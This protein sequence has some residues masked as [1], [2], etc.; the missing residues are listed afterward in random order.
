VRTHKF[1]IR[2]CAPPLK[3]SSF[4]APSLVVASHLDEAAVVRIHRSL[5]TEEADAHVVLALQNWLELKSTRTSF[6][7][8]YVTRK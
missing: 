2:H 4:S 7:Y 5:G 3:V 6:G 1:F 8:Q